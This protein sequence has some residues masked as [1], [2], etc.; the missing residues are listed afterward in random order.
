[1]K[2]LP[3]L[4]SSESK[5]FLNSLDSTINKLKKDIKKEPVENEEIIRDIKIIDLMIPVNKNKK[6]KVEKLL[7]QREE[8]LNK[9]K[10]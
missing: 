10:N 3:L 2:K 8:L 7:K 1:M 6:K 9:L 4:S 5:K